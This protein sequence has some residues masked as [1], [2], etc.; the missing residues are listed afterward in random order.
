MSILSNIVHSGGEKVVNTTSICNTL[1]SV[2]DYIFFSFTLFLLNIYQ[3]QKL[4]GFV[5]VCVTQLHLL[6]NKEM[7][8]KTHKLFVSHFLLLL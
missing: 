2:Q 1:F 5:C 8:I 6:K 4:L 7:L 3:Q